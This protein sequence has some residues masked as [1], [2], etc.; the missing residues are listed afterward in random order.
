MGNC[1]IQIFSVREYVQHQNLIESDSPQNLLF[2]FSYG[3]IASQNPGGDYFRLS[4]TIS[5][6]TTTPYLCF[7]QSGF[8]R[9]TN[10]L[11]M[12]DIANLDY[13]VTSVL[14]FYINGVIKI[15]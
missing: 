7:L 2:P 10:D 8:G 6:L 13:E 15:P 14:W 12:H 11:G 9:P 3:T 4:W 5:L 1:F